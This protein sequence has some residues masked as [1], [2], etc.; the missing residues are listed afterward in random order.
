MGKGKKRR[1]KEDNEQE[2]D[3]APKHLSIAH[4][5]N[6]EKRLIVILEQAQ[7]ESVKVGNTF[8]LLNCDDHEG[9]L[10][11]HDRMPGAVRPDITHQCLMMLL[12]SPLNRAGL[13]QIY[14]HTENN[15]LIEINPQV[16]IPRTFKRFCGLMVQL[17]HKFS[18]RASDNAMKLLKVIKNPVTD[19]LPVGCR[20]IGTSFAAE[21]V[22]N[23]RE[24]VPQE[25]PIAIVIGA[26]ARGSV[27]PD[28]IEDTI[29]ISNYPLS[30]ALTCSKLCSAF[31]EV[32]GVM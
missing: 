18:I 6:Q 1:L 22:I 2:F 30:A 16:R 23:P 12:D 26:I 5:R 4:I 25:E 21:K 29:S 10:K 7:L 32:W 24:I 9:I 31:E 17:L 19:H 15:V 13:L 20:K 8:Q 11:R 3:P 27:Q 28:Y 14:I